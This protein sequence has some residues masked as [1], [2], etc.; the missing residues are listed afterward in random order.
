[1]SFHESLPWLRP[2][3]RKGRAGLGGSHAGLPKGHE[4]LTEKASR[5]YHGIAPWGCADMGF[6][7]NQFSHDHGGLSQYYICLGQEC[8]ALYMQQSIIARE[9][10]T[11]VQVMQA[12]L[13]WRPECARRLFPVEEGGIR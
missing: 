13:L 1:V 7:S 9:P 8:V 11:R 6:W 5:S 2:T 4:Q 10:P 3:T 12:R